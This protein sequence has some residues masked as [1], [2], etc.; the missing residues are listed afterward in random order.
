MINFNN[1]ISIYLVNYPY[2]EG[3]E[4]FHHDEVKLVSIHGDGV[5]TQV[6]H[7]QGGV[8]VRRDMIEI[9]VEDGEESLGFCSRDCGVVAVWWQCGVVWCGV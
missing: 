1:V 3:H 4:V 8:S 5:K 7:E 6:A 2:L 9:F